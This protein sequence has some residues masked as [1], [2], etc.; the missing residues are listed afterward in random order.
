MPLPEGGGVW[1]PENLDEVTAQLRVWSAWYA[2]DLD[3]ISG[4]YGGDL[5]GDPARPQGGVFNPSR[6]DW[7]GKVG[8]TLARWFWGTRTPAAERRAKL[9]LPMA[10]D[11]ATASADILFGEPPTFAVD[12]RTTQAR[13]DLL[14]GSHLRATLSESAELAG[15]MGG[16][17]LRICWDT[18]IRERPWISPVHADGAIPEWRWDALVAVTFWREIAVDGNTVWRHLERHEPGHILH[19]VYEGGVNELGRPVDLAAFPET[20]GLRP[21][22]ETRTQRLTAA[23]VPNMRPAPGWRHVPAAV[24]LGRADFDGTEQLMDALDETYT[25]LM[26]DIRIGKGRLHVP[27][28][29]LESLGPGKGAVFEDRELYAP[30]TA[31]GANKLDAGLQIE[32]TQFAIRVDEH[33]RAATDLMTRIAQSSGYSAQTFGLQGD[34]GMQ[35]ATEVDA[36]KDRTLGTRAKKVNYWSPELAELTLT[37]QLI[38]RAINTGQ[39][40]TP[41]LPDVDMGDGVTES[42]RQVAETVELLARAEAASI[43][44]RVRMVHPDWDDLRVRQEVEG[45]RQDSGMFDA[46]DALTGDLRRGTPQ[47]VP[48]APPA[49]EE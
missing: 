7:R 26:R 15:G 17:Y 10:R 48:G 47:P 28:T 24:N 6:D 43:E 2:G 38:D 49:A 30:L 9:H 29:Y 1:P 39:T 19:G 5:A 45:I 23:Y 18:T 36:K 41:E 16:I 11:L 25:S 20:R 12:D 42:P 44:T 35:T 33:L 13:L 40:Y 22:V 3:T 32:A 4:I 46:G 27:A 8:R 21:D 34:G 37:L 14:A 31:I